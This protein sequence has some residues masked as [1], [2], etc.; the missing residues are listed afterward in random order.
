V[1]KEQKPLDQILRAPKAA[2]IAGVVISTLNRLS[3][4]GRFPR[5]IKIGGRSSGY[6]RSE[7]ERWLEDRKAERDNAAAGS[8]R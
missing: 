1:N 2:E 3:R 8:Q 5:K 4:S 7:V 6:L